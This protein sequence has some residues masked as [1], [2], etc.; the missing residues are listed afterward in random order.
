ML[1]LYKFIVTWCACLNMYLSGSRSLVPNMM[2]VNILFLFSV[3]QLSRVV[4]RIVCDLIVLVCIMLMLYQKI[5]IC[6]AFS[7]VSQGF[8]ITTILSHI[9]LMYFLFIYSK[10][11]LELNTFKLSTC[12]HYNAVVSCY[13][14]FS[15]VCMFCRSLFVLF[16]FFFWSLCCLSFFDLWLLIIPLVSLISSY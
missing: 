10:H 5:Y 9:Y 12:F 13:S 7:F 16:S 4:L 14:I 2:S 6:F 3:P 15:C 8:L 1:S 11:P